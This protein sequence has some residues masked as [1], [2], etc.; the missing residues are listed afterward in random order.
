MMN[1]TV[2]NIQLSL[3]NIKISQDIILYISFRCDIL[4][5]LELCYV[6][7]YVRHILVET[8]IAS[9]ISNVRNVSSSVDKTNIKLPFFII[10]FHYWNICRY[11]N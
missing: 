3:S 5:N 8:V 2:L 4:I 6:Y 10:Y 9:F 11:A 7:V 1:D